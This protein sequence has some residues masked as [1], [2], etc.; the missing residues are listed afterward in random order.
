MN[1]RRVLLDNV[2]VIC[3]FFF[4]ATRFCFPALFRVTY[5]PDGETLAFYIGPGLYNMCGAHCLVIGLD[6]S[7]N[8]QM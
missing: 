1:L 4:P 7:V 8:L 2:S 6:A 5:T 3:V